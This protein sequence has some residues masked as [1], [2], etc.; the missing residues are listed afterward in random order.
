MRVPSHDRQ[1]LTTEKLPTARWFP[2]PLPRQECRREPHLWTFGFD[3]NSS[4]FIISQPWV[5]E[6]DAE[7]QMILTHEFPSPKPRLLATFMRSDGVL[8]RML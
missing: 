2:G 6:G 7:T 3:Q 8:C 4:E 5:K 1:N